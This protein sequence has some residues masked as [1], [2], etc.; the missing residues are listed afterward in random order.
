MREISMV[1]NKSRE[2]EK[3][4]LFLELTTSFINHKMVKSNR[5]IRSTTNNSNNP[6]IRL[7]QKF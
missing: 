3:N 2:Y 4:I 6:I 5:M 1:Y 7:I